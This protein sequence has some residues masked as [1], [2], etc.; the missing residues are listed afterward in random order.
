MIAVIFR[1]ITL[2]NVKL[3]GGSDEQAQREAVT[4]TAAALGFI[5][6][7]GAVGGFFIQSVWHLFGLDRLAGGRHENILLFYIACV[8]LTGWST[9]VVSLNNNNNIRTCRTAIR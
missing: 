6:A 7:I 2:Y 3:R 1:Q 4:D 9:G 5:S 8:L